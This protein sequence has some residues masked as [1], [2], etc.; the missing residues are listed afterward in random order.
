M[1]S[2]K[3]A[4][5]NRAIE[6]KR[7]IVDSKEPLSKFGYCCPHDKLPCKR[8]DYELGAG[9]CFFYNVEGRLKFT[10]KRFVAPAGYSLPKQMS[11]EEMK[12]N[13]FLEYTKK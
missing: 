9:A 3:K 6:K 4:K 13:G 10:C 1:G 2:H 11:P 5:R 12:G 7:I 8:F